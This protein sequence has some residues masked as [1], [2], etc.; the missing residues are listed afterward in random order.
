MKC[1]LHI[2]T[3][4]TGT[5]LI[6]QWLYSNREAL[7]ARGVYLSDMLE[8]PNNRLLPAFFMARL[9]SWAKARRITTPEQK[10]AHFKG[11]PDRFR[12][13]IAEASRTHSH[14]VITSEYMHARMDDPDEIRALRAFLVEVFDNVTVVCYFRNQFD[15]IVSRYSTALKKNARSDLQSFLNAAS[16]ED[17]FYNYLAVADLW[18]AAFGR[19]NCDFRI[20]DRAEFPGGD[21]RLDFLNRIDPALDAGALDFSVESANESLYALQVSAFRALNARIPY[22]KGESGGQN[23]LNRRIKAALSKVETLKVGR[24]QSD[25]RAEIEQRFDASNRAFFQKYFGCGNRF[26]AGGPQADP[27]PDLSMG[28]VQQIVGDVVSALLPFAEQGLE[29]E[30]A[31]ALTGMADKIESG[32]TL[33][34]QEAQILRALARKAKPGGPAA[35]RKRP[36]APR[37]R[38]EARQGKVES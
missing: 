16:P 17:G 29:A 23:L 30:D 9:E 11:F 32:G 22:W 24:V 35:D 37:T 5:T 3:A 34:T 15:L 28:Q 20:Y 8:K 31:R 6:Q 10:A 21:I 25:A 4:K 1:I 19:E 2:G 14:F 13:E 7:S 36:K 38:R 18:A 33:S 12:A 26:H 27:G